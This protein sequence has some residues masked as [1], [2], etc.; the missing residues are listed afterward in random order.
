MN[1]LDSEIVKVGRVGRPRIGIGD[2]EACFELR[3]GQLKL[4]L[5][6]RLA[7][8]EQRQPGDRGRLAGQRSL[9]DD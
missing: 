6:H 7:E 2:V 3:R 8:A 9:R 4:A 1:E 5:C